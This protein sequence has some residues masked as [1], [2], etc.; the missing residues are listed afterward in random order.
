[1]LI[2]PINPSSY[3][4][5]HILT[6][7]HTVMCNCTLENTFKTINSVSR[8]V[9]LPHPLL[10]LMQLSSYLFECGRL[11]RDSN[12]SPMHVIFPLT[13]KLESFR[14][15]IN[16]GFTFLTSG[17]IYFIFYI[18]RVTGNWFKGMY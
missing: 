14:R 2:C 15:V 7:N 4:L 9:T 13:Y 16:F 12:L 5:L 11:I 17:R 10:P 18:Y 8:A 1:M 6:V 3:I